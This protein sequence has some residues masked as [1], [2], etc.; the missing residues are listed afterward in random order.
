VQ[1]NNMQ[2][3]QNYIEED[4]ID[5]RELFNTIKKHFFKIVLFSIAVT[6]ASLFYVLTIP[7]SYK[8]ET[9]LVAQEQAKVSSGGLGA[10]AGLA[11]IDLGGASGMSASDSIQSIVKDYNFNM[12]L[13][14]KYKL[15]EKLLT[16]ID[17]SNFVFP[18]GLKIFEDKVFDKTKVIQEEIDFNTYKVLQNIISVSADKKS[19]AITLSAEYHDRYL[20]KEIVDIYLKESMEYLRKSEMLEI[21]QKIKYYN[22]EISN[23]ADIELKKQLSGLVSSLIQKKVLAK[24]SEFY[25]VKKITDSRIAYIKEKSKPKRSIILIVSL[26]TSIILGIFGVFFLEFI[27]SEK[28]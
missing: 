12:T 7:N 19:S 1:E 21:N 25:I 28:K 16:K 9:I 26:I 24:A 20:A 10:L 18:F 2:I 8:S 17:T 3:Q 5:L 22:E 6:L 11:G 23:T 13:I 27:R 15:D 4:E 14:K